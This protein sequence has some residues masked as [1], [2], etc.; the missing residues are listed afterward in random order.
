AEEKYQT[1]NENTILN[2]TEQYIDTAIENIVA[3]AKTIYTNNSLYDLLNTE[4]ASAAAYYDAFYQFQENNSLIITE[5]KNIK[6]YTIYTDNSTITSGGNIVHLSKAKD[7]E[8]YQRF[9]ELNK[10]MIVFCDKENQSFSLIRKLD[11]NTIRTGDCYLKIDLSNAVI[12]NYFD[13]LDFRGN[14]Y[15]MSHSILIY[16]NTDEKNADEINITSDYKCYVKNYYTAE[17]EYYAKEQK[18]AVLEIITRNMTYLIPFLILFLLSVITAIVIVLDMTARTKKFDAIVHSE[19]TLS[20]AE[21]SL[22]YGTD[23][24]GKMF[25]NCIQFFDRLQFNQRKLKKC[26]DALEKSYENTQQIRLQALHL[27]IK[28]LCLAKYPIEKPDLD[29]SEPL[30]ID[31]EFEM[32]RKHFQ[33]RNIQHFKVILEKMPEQVTVLPFS[34]IMTADDLINPENSGIVRISENLE[35]SVRAFFKENCLHIQF[36][37]N[38]PISSGKILKLR[39]LF[40]DYPHQTDFDFQAGDIYNHYSRI[41]NYYGSHVSLE[42]TDPGNSGSES[43]NFCMTMRFS[44]RKERFY[45]YEIK[46]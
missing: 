45:N 33:N 8:W 28:N 31:F 16:S 35:I 11:Y 13:R 18:S 21:N 27:D 15:V 38:S 22:I 20:Q 39:A 41:K 4:Y 46:T 43:E 36:R 30:A 29:F 3:I 5:N 44:E 23:E 19:E 37:T 1:E 7:E 32:L 26:Y 14:L 6:K 34:V 25:A 40:E 42:I 17:L 2:S 9:C 12:E 10:P 24:L